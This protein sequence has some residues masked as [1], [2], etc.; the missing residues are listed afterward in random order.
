MRNTVLSN[1]LSYFNNKNF[2]DKFGDNF[3]KSCLELF[4]PEQSTPFYVRSIF[5]DNF[6]KNVFLDNNF[7]GQIR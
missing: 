4:E 2:R 7:W 6:G 3:G 1:L 5:L